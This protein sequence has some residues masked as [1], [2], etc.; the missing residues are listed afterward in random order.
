MVASLYKN[1]NLTKLNI[2]KK[3]TFILLIIFAFIGGEIIAQ[4]AKAM[5]SSLG[6]NL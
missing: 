4:I 6:F 1:L 2:M 5:A 3:P